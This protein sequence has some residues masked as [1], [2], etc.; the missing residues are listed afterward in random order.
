MRLFAN[1]DALDAVEIGHGKFDGV[2]GRFFAP[3]GLRHRS[4]RLGAVPGSIK[5]KRDL[6][7]K[8]INF[9][10]KPNDRVGGEVEQKHCLFCL[11]HLEPRI[12]A[13]HLDLARDHN[14]ITRHTRVD[15]IF[16]RL[17][18]HRTRDAAA[19]ASKWCWVAR[20]EKE[21]RSQTQSR[22]DHRQQSLA[23]GWFEN[24]PSVKQAN[25]STK[26]TIEM[27]E[28][29]KDQRVGGRAQW[30]KGLAAAFAVFA[31][32]GWLKLACHLTKKISA[33]KYSSL[34]Y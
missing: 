29:K 31:A 10:N 20:T 16:R 26:A 18:L 12:A 33:N 17:A 19:R 1:L 32:S 6:E 15:K 24:P 28:K 4:S 5:K 22:A 23:R 11:F 27:T 34:C 30:R 8:M 9:A 14:D 25:E 21:R 2:V 13:N 7:L 3:T